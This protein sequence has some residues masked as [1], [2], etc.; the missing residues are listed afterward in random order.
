MQAIDPV[1]TFCPFDT[2]ITLVLLRMTPTEPQNRLSWTVATTNKSASAAPRGTRLPE[3]GPTEDLE[4]LDYLCLVAQYTLH[5][6]FLA[7]P[8]KQATT[9]SS[10]RFCWTDPFCSM[11]SNFCRPSQARLH[12]GNA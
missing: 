4:G 3:I 5:V 10:S 11:H 9:P 12:Q 6:I 1:A 2:I 8:L 7:Q